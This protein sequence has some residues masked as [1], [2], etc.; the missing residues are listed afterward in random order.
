LANAVQ[1]SNHCSLREFI[2]ITTTTTTTTTIIIIIIII[3]LTALRGAW[4]SSEASAS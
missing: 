4:S 1:G 2:I 3:G